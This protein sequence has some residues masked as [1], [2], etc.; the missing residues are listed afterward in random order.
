MC[1]SAF[2]PLFAVGAGAMAAAGIGILS[3]VGGGV[4]ASVLTSGLDRLRLGGEVREP[5]REDIENGVAR[6]IQQALEAGDDRAAALRSEIA[7]VLTQVGAGQIMLQAA[8]ETG[9]ERVH[10]GFLAV[11][12]ILGDGFAELGFLIGNVARAAARF[13]RA[14]MSR[15]P[16][17]AGSSTRTTTS[18]LRSA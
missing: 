11:I 6:Q 18:P 4:L 10:A 13:R 8:I 5:S 2:C 3:S 17:S 14:L 12:E 1:A 15:A 7:W 9:S 16:M